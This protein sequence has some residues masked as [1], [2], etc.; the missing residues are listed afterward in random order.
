MSAWAVDASEMLSKL[1]LSA[2][3]LGIVLFIL[4]LVVAAGKLK[5]WG[6]VL[7]GFLYRRRTLGSAG[8]GETGKTGPTDGRTPK[9]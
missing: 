5:A 6:E 9:T 7:G 8:R 1:G 2:S 4:L 3:E